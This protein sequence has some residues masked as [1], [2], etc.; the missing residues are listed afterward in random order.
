MSVLNWLTTKLAAIGST[1]NVQRLVPWPPVLPASGAEA[2]CQTLTTGAVS[3]NLSSEQFRWWQA[4]E[5]VSC[6]LGKPHPRVE[7][8][9][10]TSGCRGSESE[11]FLQQPP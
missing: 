11:A 4:L 5:G 6:H 9:K 1:Q 3:S 7:E 2:S 10:G 8:R